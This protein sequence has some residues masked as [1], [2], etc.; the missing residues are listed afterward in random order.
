M[1]IT[2][3]NQYDHSQRGLI[4][5]QVVNALNSGSAGGSTGPTGPTGSNTGPTGPAGSIAAGV[6]GPTG[7]NPGGT[8]TGAAG[9]LGYQGPTGTAGATGFTGP[10]GGATQGAPGPYWS[11][12][13]RAVRLAQPAQ[14]VQEAEPVPLWFRLVFFGA[15]RT[16]YWTLAGSTGATG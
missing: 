3:S 6:T 5:S 9:P 7:P 8:S 10:T 4:L 11:P 12:V 14:Q 1:S 15:T 16:P 2:Q 13:R